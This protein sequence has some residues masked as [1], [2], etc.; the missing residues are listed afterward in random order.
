MGFDLSFPDNGEFDNRLYGLIGQI[1][2]TFNSLEAV[3]RES[4]AGSLGAPTDLGRVLLCRV[5]FSDLVDMFKIAACFTS[6]SWPDAADFEARVCQ[7]AKDLR[8]AND[9]RNRVVHSAYR[10]AVQITDIGGEPCAERV[11]ERIKYRRELNHALNPNLAAELV[12]SLDDLEAVLAQ[13][14]RTYS[15]LSLLS[16]HLAPPGRDRYESK[17]E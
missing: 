1:V 5:A 13:I 15:D 6:K 11:T 8:A 17:V 16:V 12:A 9:Q 14:E 10:E 2:V 7:L 4:L 3:L